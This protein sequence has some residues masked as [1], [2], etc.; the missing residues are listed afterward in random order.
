MKGLRLY[1]VVFIMISVSLLFSCMGNSGKNKPS[2]DSLAVS[3]KSIRIDG[4]RF[5]D[6]GL[7]SGLLWAETNVGAA[8]EADAGEYFSWGETKAKA[9]YAWT[10]YAFGN[11][12]DNLTKY[13]NAGGKDVLDFSDDAA[14]INWG[15]SCRM[16]TQ[17]EF[18]ELR[19]SS[20]CT[21]TWTSRTVS[22]GSSVYGYLVTSKSNGNSI[23]FPS[24]G[25]RDGEK[26]IYYG[27]R[28]YYWSST[29]NA[30][31]NFYACYLC[32]E[33]DCVYSGHDSRY[34]GL[35]VRPVAVK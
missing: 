25:C 16:P 24:V 19:D 15:K 20:N 4:H 9:D 23:F 3:E 2:G 33:S 11:G 28:G 7:P 13:K 18:V 6:L 30:L 14:Y 27:S 1:A 21:W 8:S 10:S 5:V 34:Y 31:Y 35:P 12:E 26:L 22:D 32:L 17:A 29:L